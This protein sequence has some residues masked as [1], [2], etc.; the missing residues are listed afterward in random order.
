M[1]LGISCQIANYDA[2]KNEF[3][4]IL[5]ENPLTEFVELPENCTNLQYCNILCGVI[6]GAMEMVVE[7]RE[8]Y[9]Q[10]CK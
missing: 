7:N 1:F 3:S 5:D 4:L 9:F 6:R 8:F 10:R 2:K